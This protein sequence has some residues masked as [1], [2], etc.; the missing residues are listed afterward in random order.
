M[1][2]SGLT[3]SLVLRH[4]MVLLRQQPGVHKGRDNPLSQGFGDPVIEGSINTLFDREITEAH[5]RRAGTKPTTS[6][7]TSR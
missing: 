4:F 3:F 2:K 7:S 1:A 6:P 5:E